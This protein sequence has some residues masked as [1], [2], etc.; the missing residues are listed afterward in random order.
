MFPGAVIS[1]NRFKR[2]MR[3]SAS[4]PE[5]AGEERPLIGRDPLWLLGSRLSQ[6]RKSS[7]EDC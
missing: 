5:V 3:S 2:S 6:A 1:A 7:Q 4:L